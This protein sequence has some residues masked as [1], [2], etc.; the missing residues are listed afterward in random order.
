MNLLNEAYEE[1]GKYEECL[2]SSREYY[3]ELKNTKEINDR[4]KIENLHSTTP[5]MENCYYELGYYRK[6]LLCET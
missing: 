4:S 2:K 6:A 1:N 3:H 5:R